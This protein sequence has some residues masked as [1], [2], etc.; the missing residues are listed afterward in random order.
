[1]STNLPSPFPDSCQESNVANGQDPDLEIAEKKDLVEFSTT[2][3]T[4]KISLDSLEQFKAS[5][6]LHAQL[7][8][9]SRTLYDYSRKQFW[10]NAVNII[11]LLGEVG[12]M[13]VLTQF[14][15]S[16]NPGE[17]PVSVEVYR[18]KHAALENLGILLRNATTSQETDDARAHIIQLHE[19]I[20]SGGEFIRWKSPFHSEQIDLLFS[21]TGTFIDGI[22]LSG[23]AVLAEKMQSLADYHQVVLSKARSEEIAYF[24]NKNLLVSRDQLRSL[25]AHARR[26][27]DNSNNVRKYGFPAVYSTLR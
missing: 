13:P 11:G 14:A 5:P 6:K 7:C 9:L 27:V 21:L 1:M 22:G 10:E 18:A 8:A 24:G 12:Y 26:A 25:I 15:F 2:V 16:G 23:D 17:N 3:F 19:M 20:H 4:S